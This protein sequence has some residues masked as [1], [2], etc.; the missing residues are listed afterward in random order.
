MMKE[1]KILVDKEIIEMLKKGA[2]EE[3]SP[4]PDQYLSTIFLV[5]KKD[6]GHR[7]VLN[8]KNLNKHIPY[9]H[10]KMEGLFLV[11]ELLQP[12]DYMCKLDLK[13]AYFSV[14]LE[15]GSQ[16]YIRFQ[17]RQKLYQFLCLCFGLGPAPRNFTKLMKIPIALMRKLNIRLIVFLDDILIMASSMEEAVITRDTDIFTAE[18]RI[19]NQCKEIGISPS[20]DFAISRSRNK[21]LRDDSQSS[22]R[23]EG[24]NYSTLPIYSGSVGSLNKGVDTVGRSSILIGNSSFTSTPPISVNTEATNHGVNHKGQLRSETEVITGCEKGTSGGFR[25]SISTMARH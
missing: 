4:I 10:F 5:S 2:I 23:K 1:E 3:V 25:T 15:Q 22:F 11:K 21:F 8:L 14:P 19:H 13:D 12:G 20:P 18:F 6:S 7:P 9:V 17:W 16:K 24:K